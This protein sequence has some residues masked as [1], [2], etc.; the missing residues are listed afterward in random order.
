M[1]ATL[2]VKKALDVKGKFQGTII[3]C[4]FSRLPPCDTSLNVSS[5]SL[6]L[7]VF[8]IFLCKVISTRL[9]NF[10]AKTAYTL[11]R[12]V[13]PFIGQNIATETQTVAFIFKIADRLNRYHRCLADKKFTSAIFSQK[14]AAPSRESTQV[15]KPLA[16]YGL[17]LSF[18]ALRCTIF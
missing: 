4:P 10:A 8:I 7:P 12:K 14:M 16:A 15:K 5:Q 13:M 11:F 6:S 17:N 2:S 9:T 1:E 3:A 18:D